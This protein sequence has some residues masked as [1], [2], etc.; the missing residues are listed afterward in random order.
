MLALLWAATG[1]YDGHVRIV[2][3]NLGELKLMPR[4]LVL[5][6]FARATPETRPRNVGIAFFPMKAEQ[7]LWPFSSPRIAMLY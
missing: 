1:A 5:G 6:I 2:L 4:V 3:G 7:E